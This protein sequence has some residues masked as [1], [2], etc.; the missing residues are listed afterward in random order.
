MNL[1]I[2]HGGVG[3]ALDA[4]TNSNYQDPVYIQ[5]KQEQSLPDSGIEDITLSEQNGTGA[6]PDT[7]QSDAD[8]ENKQQPNEKQ[9]QNAISRVN[10]SMKSVRTRAE[11]TYH[12]K[13]K[14]VS[15][16]IMNEDTNE[17]IR[18]IPPEES[19]KMVEK[20]W[21]LVGLFVDEKR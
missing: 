18:E 7:N 10:S 14:R 19:I 9:I 16:K 8:A 2:A 3:M 21:E 11:F 4:I 12:E 6:V 15:I 17:V 13:I 20:M 1:T 5:K